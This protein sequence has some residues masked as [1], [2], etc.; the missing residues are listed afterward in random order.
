MSNLAIVPSDSMSPSPQPR[1]AKDMDGAEVIAFLQSHFFGPVK[2]RLKKYKP[3]LLRA[4][5]IFSQ[6]GRR[7]PIRGCCAFGLG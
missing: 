7:V 3:Y 6:P 2:R 1:R 4:H 5:K